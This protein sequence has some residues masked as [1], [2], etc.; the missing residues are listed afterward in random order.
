MSSLF[1]LTGQYL[2]LA[3]QL[4]DGDFDPQT[5]ADTID[6]SGITDSIAEKAQALEFVARGAES[7]NAAIDA[8]IARLVALKAHRSKT[9]DAL[10][11]YIKRSMEAMQIER[12]EC[13]LF[14]I[15]IRKNPDAVKVLDEDQIPAEFMVTP[16]PKPPV[17]A[18][19]KKAIAA[20]IKAGQ[21][22]PGAKLT[23]STR[24][25]VK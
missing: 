6:A 3:H 1:N 20:A 7:H 12:I 2:A 16:K 14:A 15:S 23:Q 22:V 4:A 9:A 24:M 25:V 5:V 11:D 21:D 19:D 8:E 18:P 10:R 13:P 17:A